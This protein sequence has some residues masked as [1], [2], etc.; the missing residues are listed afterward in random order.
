MTNQQREGRSGMGVDDRDVRYRGRDRSV[1]RGRRLD[2]YD[3][4]DIR[5]GREYDDAPPAG[6]ASNRTPRGANGG[7]SR[8]DRPSRRDEW[9]AP[10]VR[11]DPYGGASSSGRRSRSDGAGSGSRNG[12]SGPPPRSSRSARDDY[13]DRP[14]SRDPRGRSGD[15]AMRSP[16][17]RADAW[18]AP[19]RSSGARRPPPDAGWGADAPGTMRRPRPDREDMGDPRRGPRTPRGNMAGNMDMGGQNGMGMGMGSTMRGQAPRGGLAGRPG[20]AG[21]AAAEEPAKKRGISIG[22]MLGVIVLMLAIGVGGAYGYFLFSVPKVQG[23]A[24]SGTTPANTAPA[25]TPAT[26]PSTTPSATKSPHTLIWV[27]V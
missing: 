10:T 23:D 20:M 9:D 25:T 14:S 26:T 27:I 17:P 21:V 11:N 4:N 6:R 24:P 16:G 5:G 2:A 8:S 3:D 18:D 15:R 1:D 7:G 22:M 12:P 19:P 13:D